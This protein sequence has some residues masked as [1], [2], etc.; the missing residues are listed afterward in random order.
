MYYTAIP[1]VDSLIGKGFFGADKT[2][3]EALRDV[4]PH[5]ETV[6]TVGML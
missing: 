1:I 2:P 4:S 5:N 6:E 3:D